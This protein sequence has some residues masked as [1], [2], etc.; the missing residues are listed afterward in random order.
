VRRHA[1]DG[2][3]CPT[4]RGMGRIR[5][6]G[7]R[8]VAASAVAAALIVTAGVTLTVEDADVLP[9]AAAAT[10]ADPGGQAPE[11]PTFAGATPGA[12]FVSFIGDSWT[13]GAG[14]TD[15]M[16]YAH[17]T[18]RMLGWTHRVLGIG[19][20]G[21]VRGGRPGVPFD[22]RIAA[23][24]AG[25]P[26]VVVIQGSINERKTPSG[27]LAPAVADTL[28]RLVRA[29]GP[30]TVVLV[31]G[32]SH[33]PGSSAERVDRVNDILRAEAARLHLR[34]VDVAAEGWTDPTDPTIWADHFHVND[35]GA[36]QIAGRMA[37]VLRAVVAA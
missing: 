21:Y 33:V 12:P 29:A 5:G 32:A 25:K 27:V 30:D 18:G 34:F 22:E 20:S 17:L 7:A 2:T 24:M 35:I 19:G 23:A 8:W 36:R 37:A 9:G 16:G 10:V 3:G 4:V 6:R 28:G 1:A 15:R 14:A 31:V 26:D 13:A 11:Y